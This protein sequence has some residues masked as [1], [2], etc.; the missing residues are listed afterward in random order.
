MATE[1]NESAAL[2]RKDAGM[3][4]ISP[5]EP[6]PLMVS[7]RYIEDT[8]RSLALLQ[9]MVRQVLVDGRDYG[10][11]EG[12]PGKFLWDPGASQII[13]SFNCFAGHRRVLSL[14]DDGVKLAIVLEVPLIQ[15]GSL[16]EVGSGIGASSTMEVKHRYRWVTNPGDWGYEG[17][18]VKTLKTRQKDGGRTEYRIPNPEHDE[19]LN[20][21]A[22]QASKRAEVDAAEALPG[23]A[24]VLREM[25]NTGGARN[26]PDETSPKWQR[27]WS[28]ARA[29]MPDIVDCRFETHKL[30]GVKS[31][32]DWVKGGK[33][34][35][36]A[37]KVM[38]EKLGKKTAGQP[39]RRD[40][41][42]V[43]ETEVDGGLSLQQVMFDCF[44]W[45]PARIWAEAN[46]KNLRNFEE[47]GR[48]TAWQ[49]FQRLVPLARDQ[50]RPPEGE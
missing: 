47:S 45:Q 15:R 22:K 12:V 5:A 24:S 43:K 14:I 9:D 23:V 25:F 8:K 13:G 39:L 48:E 36:D 37:L 10:H 1:R 21:V 42:T 2:A 40:P 29:M 28:A 6:Q 38:A 34:L 27:F 30:L 33:S 11:V 46:Y 50:E 35:D 20:V 41:A 17:E 44:G 49:V 7:P 4:A 16:Q 31:M 26:Y 32:Q 18:A 19:L 3:P